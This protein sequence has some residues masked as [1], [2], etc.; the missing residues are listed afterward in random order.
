MG[1]LCQRVLL[2]LFNATI[3]PL[4][5]GQVRNNP[6][7]SKEFA[8]YEQLK[9]AKRKELQSKLYYLHRQ[10]LIEKLFD[11]K[12]IKLIRLTPKGIVKALQYKFDFSKDK[13]PR[14]DKKWRIVIF[15]VEENCK[16]D[17][18]TL[19]NILLN[20]GFERL[21]KS[22]Y[23]FPHDCLPEINLAMEALSLSNE[24]KYIEA[25]R[26]ISDQELILKFKSK[27]LI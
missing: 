8:Q 19:R 24:I 7:A 15:D 2:E 10:G 20:W 22:V 6:V 3:A 4:V 27:K 23:I 16:R 26:I 18:T 1:L 13:A 25:A 12:G 21:Q 17:R 5:Y 9:N 14:W 11:T